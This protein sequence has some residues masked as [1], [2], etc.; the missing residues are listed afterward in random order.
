MPEQL[1]TRLFSIAPAALEGRRDVTVID[2]RAPGEFDL[3]HVSGA[4][5]VPLFDDDERALVGTLY[6][7]RGQSEAFDAGLEITHRKIADLV[8]RIASIAGRAHDPL[9]DLRAKVTEL[10]VGGIHALET[11]LGPE[12]RATL[13]SGALVLC[14]WR[15]GLRSQSVAALLQSLGHADAHFVEGGYKAWRAHVRAAIDTWQAPPSFTL[16]G[17]TGVGKTLVLRALEELRPGWTL[18]LEGLAGHRSSI[19]GMVGLEP[20]N[21]KIFDR[22]LFERLR[23]GFPGPCVVEGES[24]KVGDIVLPKSVWTAV[25]DGV[26]IEL[27]ASVPRRVEVLIEDY[28]ATGDAR[29][30]LARQLPY[31]EARLGS[32]KYAGVLTGLLAEGAD[33]ELVELLLERYYDPLYRHSESG[34]DYQVSIDTTDPRATAE[35]IVAWIEARGFEA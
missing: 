4:H 6:R 8:A 34:H 19:L 24:R 33:A 29:A 3:D 12:A 20:V 9:E 28:L 13:P 30:E 15:G 2:L 21:Q 1:T 7:Q 26:P 18:D 35:A 23:S 22:R 11:R 5:S 25:D 17:L 16:R 31:I 10:T 14:C 27:V 32:R